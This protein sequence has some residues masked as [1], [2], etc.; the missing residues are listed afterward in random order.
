MDNASIHHTASVADLK[1]PNNKTML[2]D[3][4]KVSAPL[5]AASKHSSSDGDDSMPSRKRKKLQ[6]SY[7]EE[8]VRVAVDSLKEK[9]GSNFTFMHGNLCMSEEVMQ[10]WMIPSPDTTM[11]LRSGGGTPYN[12]TRGS[13]A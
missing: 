4:L 10:A 1:N 9:H 6:P 3:G 8:E 7:E 12:C 13:K 11:F 5:V 2:C